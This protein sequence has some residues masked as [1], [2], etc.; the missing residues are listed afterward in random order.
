MHFYGTGGL[1]FG[2]LIAMVWLT[3]FKSNNDTFNNHLLLFQNIMFCTMCC[4]YIVYILQ[5]YC[6]V[7]CTDLYTLLTQAILMPQRK[8]GTRSIYLV[9]KHKHLEFSR[10][11]TLDSEDI[12]SYERLHLLWCMGFRL[13]DMKG[14]CAFASFKILYVFNPL[15]FVE[16][17]KLSRKARG[18]L[19]F[20]M[21]NK[22]CRFFNIWKVH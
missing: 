16:V 21:L 5:L 6:I 19:C 7:S 12:A 11:N 15:Y 8:R 14:K 13:P 22:R 10:T 17:V 1:L 9:W 18:R 20:R 2:I 3:V 4:V